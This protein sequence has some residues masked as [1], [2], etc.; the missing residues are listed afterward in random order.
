MCVH[1]NNNNGA[2][3]KKE[4]WRRK[5]VGELENLA[6]NLNCFLFFSSPFISEKNVEKKRTFFFWYTYIEIIIMKDKYLS[7]YAYIFFSHAK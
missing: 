7:T 4:R 3:N 6:Y 1:S 5:G 2:R